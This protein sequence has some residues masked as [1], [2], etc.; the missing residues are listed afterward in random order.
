MDSDTVDLQESRVSFPGPFS[1]HDV[2]VS[3]W[4][5]PFLHAQVHDGGRMTVVLDHRFGIELTVAEAEHVVPFVAE[6]IAVALGY[7][8]HPSADDDLAPV[9]SSHPKP[10]RVMTIAGFDRDAS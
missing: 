1:R 2:V 10:A 8:A 4:S 5:V 7:N 3:G 9:R 6:A